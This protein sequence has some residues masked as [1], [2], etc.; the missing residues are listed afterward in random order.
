MIVL[1]PDY[2]IL[3]ANTAYKRQFGTVDKPYIGHKFYRISHHYDVPCD[4]GGEHRPMK[5]AFEVKGPDRVLHRSNAKPAC[6]VSRTS[7]APH[8]SWRG[9]FSARSETKTTF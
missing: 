9:F 1:D 5:R 8:K 3:A 6:S 2:N 7:G 4:Q